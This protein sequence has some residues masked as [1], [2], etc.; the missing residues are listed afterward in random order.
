MNQRYLLLVA[1]ACAACSPTKNAGGVSADV[2]NDAAAEIAGG[3]ATAG[4]AG[5]DAG[6]TDAGAQDVAADVQDVAADVQD[7]A[8]GKDAVAEI[9]SQDVGKDSA[10]TDASSSPDIAASKDVSV[11]DGQ[12]T[13]EQACKSSTGM[14]KSP[15]ASFGC[16]ICFPGPSTCQAS[17]DCQPGEVC[18]AKA[19]SCDGANA[20]QPGCKSDAECDQSAIGQVCGAD[21]ECKPVACKTVNQDADCPTDFECLL[22]TSGAAMCMRKGCSAS[23]QCQGVCVNGSCYDQPGT[24][25]FPPP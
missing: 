19:C 20:C 3:D 11:G 18:K 9:A 21:G 14:C 17:A 25:G 13:T 23:S 8:S 2:G 16:G 5:S 4:D 10:G 15:G 6:G 22:G 7:V 1:L 24:C 12:C